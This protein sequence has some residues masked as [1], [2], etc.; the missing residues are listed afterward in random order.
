MRG[1]RE[2]AGTG[3]P[4]PTSPAC[5]SHCAF[6]EHLLCAR[7]GTGLFHGCRL[8]LAAAPHGGHHR[9]HFTGKEAE[10]WQDEDLLKTSEC[11]RGRAGARI[12]TVTLPSASSTHCPPTSAVPGETESSGAPNSMAVRQAPQGTWQTDPSV[13]SPPAG[14]ALSMGWDHVRAG[15]EDPM[16]GPFPGLTGQGASGCPL[17]AA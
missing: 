8:I 12:Q 13:T 5:P 1:P 7:G 10:T 16:R 9:P 15:T 6:P 17:E 11:V 2:A 3:D 4:T 14:P